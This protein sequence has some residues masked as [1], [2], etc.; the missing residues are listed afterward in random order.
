[1]TERRH[2]GEG[3][4]TLGIIKVCVNPVITS[5]V[6]DCREIRAHPAA[7]AFKTV[8][9]AATFLEEEFFTAVGH[10]AGNE[11]AYQI[12]HGSSYHQAKI[13]F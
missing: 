9:L 7:P 5:Q 4:D 1:M 8:T 13:L 2:P 6:G 11:L 3:I 12:Q 10:T